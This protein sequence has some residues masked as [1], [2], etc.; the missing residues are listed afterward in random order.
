MRAGGVWLG[1]WSYGMRGLLPMVLLE[2]AEQ[3][4]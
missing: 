1:N 2:V 4:C 3:Q